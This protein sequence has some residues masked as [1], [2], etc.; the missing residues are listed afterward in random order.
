[1]V[2]GIA[3][4]PLHDGRVPP[5]LMRY[6]K[7]LGRAIAEIIIDE[8]GPRELVARLADP[9]WF[10]AF[11]NVIGMDWD[12]SGSTTVVVYVLKSFANVE[13][14]RDL[15][16]AV[17]GGKGS[18]AR[19][20][21]QELQILGRYLDAQRLELVSRLSAKIDSAGLQD[22]YE[23]YI[24]S[25]IVSEDGSW[26]VVQ[27]GMN[28]ERLMARRYHL[29]GEELPRTSSD[30]HTGIACNLR[31]VAL[32]MVDD[33]SERCRKTVL[34]LVND[35][36]RALIED[37]REVNR[38]LKGVRTLF[39]EAPRVKV[40]ELRKINPRFYRPI[41]DTERVEKIV[42]KLCEYR[43][44][45]FEEL[46]L[47]QGMGPEA[48]RALALVA[49]LIYGAKPSFRDPVTHAM[50]PFV[51][52]YAHGGKDGVPYPVR[53]DLL[54]NTISFL[55]NAVD[56]ARIDS[57]LRRQALRR[58]ATFARNVLSYLR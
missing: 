5:W 34:D 55:E 48:I 17:L 42:K 10:Q 19:R 11:S 3:E 22:G 6:M 16:I 27:Q 39:G 20:V 38:I 18:D 26:T 13:T 36:P 32:N 7:R 2:E 21:P 47:F 33:S 30:P 40:D 28:V 58:L 15:G 35:S 44:K 41:I 45:S 25:L 37:L 31:G 4:L 56:R 51:Y 14:F 57:E 49:D 9:L 50:D 23:L 24:H 54:E 52:A 53:R 8:Y 43:P 46:L 29:H 1:V 12:S